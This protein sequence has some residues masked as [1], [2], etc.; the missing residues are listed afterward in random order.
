MI[1]LSRK[2]FG[3]YIEKVKIVLNLIKKQHNIPETT[4]T[5]NTFE[6]KPSQKS[7]SYT[8]FTVKQVKT[9]TSLPMVRK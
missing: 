4:K 8:N 9:V 3:F 6:L 7:I 2:I 5:L 1:E